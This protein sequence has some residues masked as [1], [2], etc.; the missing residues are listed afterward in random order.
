MASKTS[1]PRNRSH[2]PRCP[3]LWPTTSM[4]GRAPAQRIWSL[5]VRFRRLHTT[6]MRCLRGKRCMPPST[7]KQRQGGRPP[8]TFTAA[9][10]QTAVFTY[11]VAGQQN[12][13]TA[14]PFSWTAVSGALGYYLYVGTSAGA[15]DLVNTGEI[16]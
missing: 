6:S 7:Q 13:S 4:L 5:P 11:P 15:K 10:V 14:Q 8:I 2:G 16:Q 12:V 9:A 3:V 1:T